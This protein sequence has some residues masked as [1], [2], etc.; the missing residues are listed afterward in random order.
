MACSFVIE[1]LILELIEFNALEAN[2]IA[3]AAPNTLPPNA[4]ERIDAPTLSPVPIH[5]V[6]SCRVFAFLS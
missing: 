1:V 5:P 6:C 2:E 3:A 4:P